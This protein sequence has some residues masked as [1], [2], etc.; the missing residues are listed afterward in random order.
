MFSIIIPS[1]NNLRYLQL[2]INSIKK[3]SSYEHEI[4][5]HVNEGSD[6][7]LDYLSKNNINYTH[8][9]ENIGLC[10]AVNIAA[11]KSIMDYILYSHDDM[12]FLPGWDNC[13]IEEI[14]KTKDD[15]FYLSSTQISPN[16]PGPKGIEHIQYDAG[17]DIDSFNEK[18]LLGTFNSFEFSDLQG[19]HWAPHLIS[20]NIWTKVKGFSEEFNPG[21]ASDPD[22]NMK[23]WNIGVRYF[24]MVSNSRVYHFS[25]ITTRKKNQITRNKGKKTFLKK[26]KITPDFFAK[27]YLKR[28]EIF[29]GP[30]EN[31]PKKNLFYYIELLLVKIK[32][33]IAIFK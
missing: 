30:L 10:S 4:I 22:L 27:H 12:Y 1:F 33:F 21:F 6:G 31:V 5:V 20:K 11:N 7:T 2:C 28:G 24:K 32:Y 14:K 9:E 18:K 15:M 8:S 13:L 3:N 25:S 29:D 23:L 17:T 26:W 19:T 16:G